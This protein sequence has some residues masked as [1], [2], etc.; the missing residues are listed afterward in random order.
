[1]QNQALLTTYSTLSVGFLKSYIVTMR[2]YL[3][4][5]SGITGMVGLSTVPEIDAVTVGIIFAASFLSY[6]FGQAL[7]DCFQT[8][9]DSISAPY[10]P[11]TQGTVSKKQVLLVSILG[12]IL[13]TLAFAVYNALTLILGL[14]AVGGLAT[15]TWFK[16]KWWA[17]PFY[18]A[19]IVVVVCSMAY[20]AGFGNSFLPNLPHEFIWIS[21][22]VFFGYANF[23]LTG[24]FKDT[25]ADVATGYN[26]L[27]V[28]FGRKAAAWVSDGFAVLTI[29]FT[30]LAIAAVGHGSIS[31]VGGGLFFTAGTSAAVLAQV[32]LHNVTTDENAHRAITPVVHSYIFLLS[33]I[34]AAQ[35]PSWIPF[36][37]MFY[38]CFIAVLQCRPAQNQI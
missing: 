13:C 18:N 8:D 14:C 19:W 29:A 15:Y 7:T 34:V 26:T 9:T 22:A 12:L 21:L 1:M 24:Y 5:V 17:G 2:P 20:A 25:R 4:F 28:V 6:G 30:A 36:L 10:R 11:L 37:S 23:V 35:K 31:I 33:S 27:P 38:L 32:R 16:R 3:L